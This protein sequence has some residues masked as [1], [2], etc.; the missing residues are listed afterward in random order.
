[1]GGS[2]QTE[3]RIWN[4]T[5]TAPMAE[6]HASVAQS[7]AVHW[8]L[9][10]AG[11][12]ASCSRA[13]QNSFCT[14]SCWDSTTTVVIERKSGIQLPYRRTY[15]EAASIGI[16]IQNEEYTTKC[17]CV[18]IHLEMQCLHSIYPELISKPIIIICY[19]YWLTCI[20]H[21]DGCEGGAYKIHLCYFACL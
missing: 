4:W 11:E 1:M 16:D 19:K 5:A 14:V 8:R 15:I 7:E 3:N 20:T 21:D 17:R 13:E 9:G 2:E 6:V 12:P 18:Y 10:L